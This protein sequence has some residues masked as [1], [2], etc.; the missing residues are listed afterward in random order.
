MKKAAKI[1]GAG[2]AAIVAFAVQAGTV[3]AASNT[4]IT[5]NDPL[6]GANFTTVANNVIFF[7][8]TTIAI[9]LTAIMV[10]VGA[11]QM[12]TSAGDPEKISKGR[13]TLLYA[14]IGFVVALIATGVTS[15]IKS[16][17]TGS[18]S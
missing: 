12:T 4:S 3:L 11:F 8:S 18:A 9:P 7:L 15:I 5:L 14:A 2:W 16:V 6:G 10:L 13:K 1:A 17:I